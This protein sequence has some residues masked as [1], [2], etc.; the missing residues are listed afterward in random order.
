MQELNAIARVAMGLVCV[1][2][3]SSAAQAEGIVNIKGYGSDGAGASIYS[4]PVAPGTIVSL[5]NPVLVDFKAGDY[6][7]SD[8]WGLAGALYNSWNFE[9]P[10]PGS[11][12]SHFVAA[13]SL[14]GGQYKLLVDGVTLL[15]PT[16]KN[17]FC[18]WDTEAEAT[19]A[20]LATPPFVMH[21]DHDATVA[22]ASADYYLPDNLGGISLKVSPV[23]EPAAYLMTMAGIAVLARRHAAISKG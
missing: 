20:F 17:H 13:E 4:Y 16:C 8:A 15:E 2:L 18:A 11:W 12:G 22:F 23:P 7:L 14:G 9:S 10:A 19:A 1:L 3:G 21:L 5:F 6:L